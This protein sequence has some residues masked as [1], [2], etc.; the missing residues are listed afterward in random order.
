MT[1]IVVLGSTGMLGHKVF[2]YFSN[3]EGYEVFGSYRN[4]LVAPARNSFAFDAENP[5]WSNIPECDYVLNCI[6]VIKPFMK[7][8]TV[9][10]I[11][12][13]SLF[14]W[15]LSGWCEDNNTRLIHITTDC[16]FSGNDG[17][18]T[19]KSLHDCLDD[20]GKSKSLGE[21]TNCMVIRTSIIGEE[22]HKNASLIA[23]AKSQKGT[24]INGF[25]NHYWNGITTLE[26]AKVCQQI[27]D[28]GLHSVGLFH[29]HSPEPVNKLE[30]LKFISDRFKL[31]LNINSFE[32]ENICDRTLCT[33]KNLVKNLNISSIE[34]QIGEL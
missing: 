30:L 18:Y 3:L 20:Y 6:G 23:W 2:E 24:T 10:A 13:N 17:S 16:V 12:I 25:T 31:E 32:T 7:D 33:N 28:S 29:V 21:P 4:E 1:R 34:N 27:I 22:I 5:V 14:P 26:Y 15:V 9:G 11:K 8:N 19:E